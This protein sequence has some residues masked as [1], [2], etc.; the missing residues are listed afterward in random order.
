MDG[1]W[2]LSCTEY[3]NMGYLEESPNA[4]SPI[5][6]QNGLGLQPDQKKTLSATRPNVYQFYSTNGHPTPLP[7]FLRARENGDYRQ[8][9]N[10]ATS[11][12]TK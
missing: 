11:F 2:F 1:G 6:H 9:S 4:L 5:L 3:G 10:S 12:T 7:R 8:A